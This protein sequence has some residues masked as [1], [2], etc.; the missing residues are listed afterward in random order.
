LFRIAQES[1][2]N[3]RKYAKATQVKLGLFEEEGKVVLS[4][5][6]NGQGFETHSVEVHGHGIAGM[7]HRTQMFDGTLM[8]HSAPGK[9]THIEVRLPLKPS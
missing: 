4:I 5:H 2:T 1:L 3:V 7:K 8:L 9:G 6:D